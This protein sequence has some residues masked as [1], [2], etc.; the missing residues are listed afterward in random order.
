[1]NDLMQRILADKLKTRKS[2]AALPFEQKLTILEKMR[3]RSS[4]IAGN[5]LRTRRASAMPFVAV[6]GDVVVLSG[7]VSQRLASKPLV[8]RQYSDQPNT[9]QNSET[10]VV[11]SKTQSVGLPVSYLVVS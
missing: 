11:E 3:D 7:L 9:L 4:L 10:K 2:L 8:F 1:M 5:V 6:S